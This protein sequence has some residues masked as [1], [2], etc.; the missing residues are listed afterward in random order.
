[1][2]ARPQPQNQGVQNLLNPQTLRFVG[3]PEQ[4]CCSGRVDDKP[5]LGSCISTLPTPQLSRPLHGFVPI[6]NQNPAHQNTRHVGIFS[7]VFSMFLCVCVWVC[8]CVGV[9]ACLNHTTGARGPPP[10]LPSII[11]TFRGKSRGRCN[12]MVVCSAFK[13]FSLCQHEKNI[14]HPRTSTRATLRNLGA[15]LGEG[16]GA[17]SRWTRPAPTWPPRS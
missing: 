13:R 7:L 11:S 5:Q 14:R 3:N 15:F 16:T 6:V 9:C 17:R 4:P 1:M 2:A 8:R 12:Q 10:T